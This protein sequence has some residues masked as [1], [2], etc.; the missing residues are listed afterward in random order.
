MK[1]SAITDGDPSRT[2][3]TSSALCRAGGLPS[4]A[5]LEAAAPRPSDDAAASNAV[6]LTPAEP[7]GGGLPL[8]EMGTRRPA[9][10]AR[11]TP[12]S[13]HPP[14]RAADSS[15]A[16][17]P[18]PVPKSDLWHETMKDVPLNDLRELL[19]LRTQLGRLSPSFVPSPNATIPHPASPTVPE[20]VDAPS[21]A[22]PPT[23]PVTPPYLPAGPS[24][25]VTGRPEG[26]RISSETLAAIDRARQ[27]ILNNIA[28]AATNGY[29]RHLVAFETA[30][31]P[32][33]LAPLAEGLLQIPLGSPLECG[34]RMTLTLESHGRKDRTDR[35]QSRPGGRRRRV[36]PRR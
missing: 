10:E 14:S 1:L 36:L 12:A 29:K 3:P 16:S 31:T 20:P 26:E 9:N 6:P 35:P 25:P 24:S 32:P 23:G 19:R 5:P 15:T 18:I 21:R 30:A 4:P 13:P 8:Q 27:A 7:I 34:S 17:F 22:L 2:H 33:P 11:R 28:N